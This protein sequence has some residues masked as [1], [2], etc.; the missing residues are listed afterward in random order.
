MREI[1]DSH[2]HINQGDAPRHR[3]LATPLRPPG[4]HVTDLGPAARA[5]YEAL[6][7]RFMRVPNPTLV[8]Y[9]FPHLAG[10]HRVPVP[11][12]STVFPLYERPEY[13]LPGEH[14]VDAP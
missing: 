6:S 3:Q 8:M 10:I 1:Y 11:G 9:I 13:A 14:A 7:A 2:V 12:S 4:H 5:D